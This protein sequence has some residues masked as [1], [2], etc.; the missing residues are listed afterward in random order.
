M[1]I[2]VARKPTCV[3]WPVCCANKRGSC[4]ASAI[5]HQEISK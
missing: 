1:R 4:T 5:N 3:I 2:E